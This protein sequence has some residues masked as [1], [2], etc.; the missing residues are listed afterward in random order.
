MGRSSGVAWSVTVTIHDY[1]IL[2]LH[3]KY[4]KNIGK[5]YWDLNLNLSV[6]L[7]ENMD[8]NES[9]I[10]NENLNLNINMNLNLN[11]NLILSK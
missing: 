5:K 1:L 3:Q 4:Q 11:L 8:L 10:L 9:M 6:N 2:L 7:N